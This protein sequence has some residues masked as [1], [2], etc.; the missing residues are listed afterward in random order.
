LVEKVASSLARAQVRSAV[1]AMEYLLK[2]TKRKKAPK[3]ASAPTDET[4][5]APSETVDIE[6]LIAS[7]EKEKA[8]SK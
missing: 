6:A 7:Y 8:G 2:T 1:D 3:A 5:P 4:E